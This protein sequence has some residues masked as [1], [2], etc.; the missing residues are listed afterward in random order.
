MPQ[1]ESVLLDINERYPTKTSNRRAVNMRLVAG[2]AILA[3][4]AVAAVVGLTVQANSNKVELA[5]GADRVARRLGYSLDRKATQFTML[6]EEAAGEEEA[7][8][9]IVAAVP[10]ISAVAGAHAASRGAAG[11]ANALESQIGDLKKEIQAI[12]NTKE[13]EAKLQA[14]IAQDRR[15]DEADVAHELAL[16]KTLA[17]LKLL[18]KEKFDQINMDKEKEGGLTAEEAAQLDQ[19]ILSLENS[20]KVLESKMM[21]IEH[22]IT[23]LHAHEKM[24]RN[25]VADGEAVLHAEAVEQAEEEAAHEATEADEALLNKQLEVEYADQT[26]I[27]NI[28][29]EINA[30]KSFIETLGKHID[31]SDSLSD[32]EKSQLEAELKAEEADLARLEEQLTEE[33]GK[34][35]KDAEQGAS[36]R[37]KYAGDLAREHYDEMEIS[38][39]VNEMH[40]I[41]YPSPPAKEEAAE[42]EAK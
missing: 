41:L 31:A 20:L 14:K 11:E 21:E 6:E 17:E 34:L 13:L 5:T 33:Q 1:E 28:E 16:Q 9:P 23:A 15:N 38:M 10:A 12:A 24:S 42:E 30:D 27:T 4:V 35:A 32:A 29:A 36:L 40:N 8:E 26:E 39:D 18:A 22:D 2:T 19:Q 3:L 7:A 37:E 25:A